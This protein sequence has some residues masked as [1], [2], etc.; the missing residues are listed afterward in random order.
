MHLERS[1]TPKNGLMMA[2]RHDNPMPYKPGNLAEARLLMETLCRN[3]MEELSKDR[4]DWGYVHKLND[5]I[6][7]TREL[8][9]DLELEEGFRRGP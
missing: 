6:E 9:E 4:P 1:R 3:W 7:Q 8:I 5:W 2:V